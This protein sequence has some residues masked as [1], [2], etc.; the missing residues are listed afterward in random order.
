MNVLYKKRTIGGCVFL[1]WWWCMERE[2]Y[3]YWGD[4]SRVYMV[5]NVINVATDLLGS[6]SYDVMVNMGGTWASATWYRGSSW[7]DMGGV[8]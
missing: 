2:H 7:Y 8:G 3:N 1:T 4:W 5:E 6:A